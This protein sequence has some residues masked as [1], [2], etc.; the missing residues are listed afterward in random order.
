LVLNIL[1]FFEVRC[2]I[3]FFLIVSVSNRLLNEIIVLG[4]LSF[5]GFIMWLCLWF[6]KHLLTVVK[7]VSWTTFLLEVLECLCIVS[8]LV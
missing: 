6:N 4:L 8:S 7:Y 5:H 2:L 3:K 1:F